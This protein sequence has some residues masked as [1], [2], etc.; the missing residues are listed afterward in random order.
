M[1]ITGGQAGGRILK[2]P[3]GLAVRPTI[4]RLKQALFN[5]LGGRVVDARV[6]ELFAGSGALSLESLSRGA[7]SA[8]CVEL[9]PRHAAFIRSNVTAAGLPVDRLIVRTQDVFAALPQLRAAGQ[10]FDLILADPPYGEK[11]RACRST[12]FAQRLLDDP[13]LPGLLAPGGR[14]ALGYA[15]R[16]RLETPPVWREHKQLR[17]G[18]SVIG[19]WSVEAPEGI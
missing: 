17:H 11:N 9:S 2:V 13:H 6:L 14:L 19:F 1:R 18:D 4:E 3:K 8:V 12:S 16:D 5:S 15:R 7:Q 10:L